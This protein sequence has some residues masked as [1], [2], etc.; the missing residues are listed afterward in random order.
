MSIRL[1]VGVAARTADNDNEGGELAQ[2]MEALGDDERAAG[3]IRFGRDDKVDRCYS[4]SSISL[5]G[6]HCSL[7][8]VHGTP[9]KSKE[10][11]G[12]W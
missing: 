1:Q 3:G 5:A 2:L 6:P 7:H 9:S 12:I 11:S 4:A 10:C 8:A